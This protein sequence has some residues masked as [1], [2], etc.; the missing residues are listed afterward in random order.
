MRRLLPLLI[1]LLAAGVGAMRAG[2]MKQVPGD[3]LRYHRAG[4]LVVT[5][6]AE[7]LYDMKFLA[8]QAV[9]AQEREP[10][11]LTEYEF[12]YAPALAVMMAP[13]GA[14]PPR[15]ANV[16]WCAWNA[17]L[18]AG[19]FLV[20]WRWCAAG[21]PA[22]SMLWMLVPIVV[23]LRPILDNVNNGQVN[24]AAIVPATI[25]AWLLSRG[26]DRTGGALV[27]FGAAVKFMPGV[28]AL[29]FAWK[30]RWRALG[31]C[32]AV[33]VVLW[34]AL[35]TAVFGPSKALALNEAW[36]DA[37]AHHFTSA[38]S[39][40]LPGYSVK[41][42]VYRLLGSTPYHVDDR[43][44]GERSTV[45][46][47]A[48]V[49]DPGA[50]RTLTIVLDVILVLT[51]LWLCRGPVRDASDPRGP[52]EAALMLA[53]LPLVSPEARY[54]HFLFLALPLTALTFALVRDR[55]PSPARRTVLALTVLGAVFV[56][57]TS[58]KLFGKSLGLLAEVYCV[59][60]WGAL[61][62]FTALALLVRDARRTQAA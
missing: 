7:R 23:L 10:G 4:R 53:L 8:T 35:P 19:M 52:P 61:L 17:A 2:A 50:L 29:W 54:P 55:G 6:R 56:N 11:K 18:M 51:A 24:P 39:D 3:F 40:D 48:D 5:G 44:T 37:R 34:V 9:Y 13:L 22:W 36:I 15:A 49:L 45:N 32:V 21:L 27:G 33:V 59:P 28:L 14:L 12:K 46:V 47:G 58:D 43:D 26:R 31:A 20:L 42:F 1:V 60:G 57:A 16:I 38:A 30:R 25:G 41:S 62:L